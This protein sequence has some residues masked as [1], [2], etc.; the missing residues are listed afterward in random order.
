MRI[1]PALTLCLFAT[2][3]L[4]QA[5]NEA[6]SVGVVE[7]EA[8]ETLVIAAGRSDAIH[9]T[10]RLQNLGDGDVSIGSGDAFFDLSPGNTLDYMISD[11]VLQVTFRENA[12]VEFHLIAISPAP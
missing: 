1:L 11:A 4:S 8:G 3:A 2:P 9:R 5:V 12:E 10:Y 7:G 6:Q